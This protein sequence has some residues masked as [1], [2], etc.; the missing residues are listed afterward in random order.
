MTSIY[1]NSLTSVD[2]FMESVL[3]SIRPSLTESSQISVI[4]TFGPFFPARADLLSSLF[5]TS[6]SLVQSPVPCLSWCFYP[7][8]IF[9]SPILH[10]DILTTVAPSPSANIQLPNLSSKVSPLNALVRFLLLLSLSQPTLY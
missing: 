2:A 5:S 1:A 6:C 7:S 8:S 10:F 9:P 4:T 3:H